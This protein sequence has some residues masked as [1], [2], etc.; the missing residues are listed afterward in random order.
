MFSCY[1]L[2]TACIREKYIKREREQ[3]NTRQAMR[4][5][6]RLKCTGVAELMCIF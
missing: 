1:A 4:N 3:E 5:E 2:S 6:D